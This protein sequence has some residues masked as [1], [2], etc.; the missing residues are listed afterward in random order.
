MKTY[1]NILKVSALKDGKATMTA[2]KMETRRFT[3]KTRRL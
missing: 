2:T 3:F 1:I